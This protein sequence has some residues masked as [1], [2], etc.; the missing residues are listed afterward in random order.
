[1]KLVV[2]EHCCLHAVPKPYNKQVP[3]ASS[4]PGFMGLMFFCL[5]IYGVYGLVGFMGFIGFRVI[6]VIRV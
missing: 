6:T 2:G 4:S 1:M 3:T 5:R